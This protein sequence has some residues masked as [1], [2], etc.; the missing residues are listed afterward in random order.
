MPVPRSLPLTLAAATLLATA[1]C[2]QDYFDGA[3]NGRAYDQSPA[4]AAQ[5]R[6]PALPP[7]PELRMQVVARGLEHPWGLAELP[8]GRW[9]VTERP[10]RMRIVGADGSLSQPIAGLPQVDARDQGG[11][12]DVSVA[13]DFAQTRRVWWTYAEPRDGG[14]NA[15]A[16][17]TGIL[18]G[19]GTRMEQ[20]QRIWQQQPAWAS[21]KHFGARI[22][23]DGQGHILVGLG[24]RSNPE[25]RE[26]AQDPQ[27]TLGKVIRIRASDG[28][29]AGAGI[30]GWLPEIWTIGHR[31][32]QGAAIGPDGRIWT[33]EHGPKGGDE[34]NLIEQ[35]E[36]HGWPLATY[37]T[38]YDGARMGATQVDGTDQPIYYWDPSP[39]LSGMA[40]YDGAMF[41][42]WQGQALLGGLQSQS[43]I[44]LRIEGDEVTGEARHLQGVGRVREVE[45]AS[46]GAIM[47]ITDQDDGRL[48]RV[49]PEG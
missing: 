44:R 11:L 42:E 27:T 10:G 22:V 41:P 39:A 23:H 9:L 17:A 12:H 20:V 29:P 19:D 16:V 18:S 47:L 33:T 7:G 5:T 36:N 37:G 1:A 43:I 40:F 21:T 31:N 34:L 49:T 35:G 14:R 46:D 3:P 26:L 48:I 4:F 2:A 24:E 8:E 45:V 28:A 30:E 25:P 6:A 13:D 15:T 32:I 38:N